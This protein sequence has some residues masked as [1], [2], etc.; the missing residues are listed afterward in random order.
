MEIKKCHQLSL[1]RFLLIVFWG[2]TMGCSVTAEPLP[3]PTFHSVDASCRLSDVLTL[4][5]EELVD[6]S[7]V[8]Q[9][10]TLFFESAEVVSS[11]VMHERFD[12][13]PCYI[14]GKT[15]VDEEV[16]R[17]EVRAGMTGI[18]DCP[19]ETQ[20]FGCQSEVCA[21]MFLSD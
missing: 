7:V 6:P 9:K 19:L 12:F 10:V 8:N 15:L 13:A 14:T 17:F 18:I 16:C 1:L 20:Y 4:T 11:R 2:A 3:S 21:S 5:S